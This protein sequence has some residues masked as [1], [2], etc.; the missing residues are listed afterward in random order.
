MLLERLLQHCPENRNAF[1]QIG[2]HIRVIRPCAIA[3]D[4][5][6]PLPPLLMIVKPVFPRTTAAS[7]PRYPD[8]SGALCAV[9]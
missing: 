2:P 7:A 4:I 3:S 8:G 1:P 9:V 6:G 5:A